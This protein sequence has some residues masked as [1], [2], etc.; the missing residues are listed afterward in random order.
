MQAYLHLVDAG[1]VLSDLSIRAYSGS[2]APVSLADVTMSALSTGTDYVLEGVP[3]VSPRGGLTLTFEQP[4][5][6]YS[7]YR[8]GTAA[9]QPATV[10]IPI[11]AISADP[12]AD[13]GITVFRDGAEVNPGDWSAAQIAADGEY[14]V[15][16][17]PTPSAHG[18]QWSVRWQYE[19]L[20]YSVQWVGTAPAEQMDGAG[21][22]AAV[23]DV[24][25]R[26]GFP[27]HIRVAG[28][29]LGKGFLD[30]EEVDIPVGPAAE[31]VEVSMPDLPA[32][33]LTSGGTDTAMVGAPRPRPLLYA[34]YFGPTGRG[35]RAGIAAS[36]AV[37]ALFAGSEISDIN[38]GAEFEAGIAHRIIGVGPASF[39]T[40]PFVQVQASV[41]G[42]ML[43]RRVA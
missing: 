2:G 40:G 14:S 12:V 20:A 35:A 34:R 24:V 4:A 25:I 22:L 23:E 18:E 31:W 39:A 15:G 11:R 17:W 9:E 10:V 7:A 42:T 29:N 3:E 30:G 26:A 16:G 38:G 28:Q 43:Y 41:R 37:C 19:D 1:L 27:F 33:Q 5:G 6:A 8:I 36:R 21:V 32:D 13:Y